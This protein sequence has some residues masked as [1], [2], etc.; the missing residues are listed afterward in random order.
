MSWS[1]RLGSELLLVKVRAD[2]SVRSQVLETVQLF[3]A[4]VVDV[5]RGADCRSRD[6]GQTGRVAA[7]AGAVRHSRAGQSGTIAI[8]R[9]PRSI[10]ASAVR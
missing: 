7:D 10:C 2:A 6:Q 1:G 3:R 9:G 4:K 8:G 5:T